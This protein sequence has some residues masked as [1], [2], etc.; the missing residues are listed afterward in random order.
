ML[1][2]PSIFGIFPV[3]RLEMDPHEIQKTGYQFKA[4]SA[5]LK[6]TK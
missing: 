5:G 6:P 2:A 3:L 4:R 1:S